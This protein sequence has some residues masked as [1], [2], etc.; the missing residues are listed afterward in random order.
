M[1]KGWILK[2]ALLAGIMLFWH[3]T[4]LPVKTGAENEEGLIGRGI[5]LNKTG[6]APAHNMLILVLEI[7]V[8]E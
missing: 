6:V 2:S 3:Q 7:V 8:I 1:R 5:T 4:C